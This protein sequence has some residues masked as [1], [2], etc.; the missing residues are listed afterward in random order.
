[1]NESTYSKKPMYITVI[2]LSIL[3]AVAWA[4]MLAKRKPDMVIKDNIRITYNHV[5]EEDVGF[6]YRINITVSTPPKAGP[7]QAPGSNERTTSDK[8]I[9]IPN[10][11]A[12]IYWMKGENFSRCSSEQKSDFSVITMSA[13]AKGDFFAGELPAREKNTRYYFFIEVT[14]SANNIVSTLPENALEKSRF[15]SV[16][17]K[18]DPNKT[19]LLVHIMLMLAA[20]FFVIH[21]L[22]YVFDYIWNKRDWALIKSTSALFWGLVCYGISAFPLGIWLAYEKFGN[23]WT[24]FPL[25]WN[26]TDSKTLF[27][28]LYWLVLVIMMKGTIFSKDKNKDMVSYKTYAWLAIIGVILTMVVRFAIPHGD[29][30]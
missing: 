1:M 19:G 3:L 7:P 26:T 11:G 29:I 5:K 14:D 13:T 17:Y 6:P 28:F 12:K 15:Y 8:S 25:G 27:N 10:D 21:T 9:S 18:Q 24:G 30:K 4:F 20:L 23:Y 2:L 22:Y 16:I